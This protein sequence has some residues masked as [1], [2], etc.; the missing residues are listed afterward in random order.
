M[1]IQKSTALVISSSPPLVVSLLVVS[2]MVLAP[3]PVAVVVL[4]VKPE[5]ALEISSPEAC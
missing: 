5:V 1:V 4:P 3:S 2:S